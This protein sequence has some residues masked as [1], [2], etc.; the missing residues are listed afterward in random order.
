M[1]V[2]KELGNGRHRKKR[3]GKRA[4]SGNKGCHNKIRNDNWSRSPSS[5]IC[6]TEWTVQVIPTCDT[7]K[8]LLEYSKYNGKMQYLESFVM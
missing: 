5:F 3:E 6:V 1:N 4:S 7:E 2:L 8:M